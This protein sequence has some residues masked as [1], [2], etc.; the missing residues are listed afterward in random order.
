ML[1]ISY[2]RR[3][4]C[5]LLWRLWKETASFFMMQAW[6]VNCAV[7]VLAPWAVQALS[8]SSSLAASPKA[9]GGSSYV[10]YASEPSGWTC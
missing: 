6:T 2:V 8:K 10:A 9:K 1:A 7:A 3:D 4:N 5:D